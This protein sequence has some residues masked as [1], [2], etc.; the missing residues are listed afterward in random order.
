MPPRV[1]AA[2]IS[3]NITPVGP[4]PRLKLREKY[5]GRKEPTPAAAKLVTAMAAT[6]CQKAGLAA[7]RR[8]IA[9]TLGAGASA[10][11]A[12]GSDRPRGGSL[13]VSQASTATSR[14]GRPSTQNTIRQDVAPAR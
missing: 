7:R 9:S 11:G 13:R 3:P 2:L 8:Q 14:P 12:D 10:P 1:E 4:S 6:T 5:C